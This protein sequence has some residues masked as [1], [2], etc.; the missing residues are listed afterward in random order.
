MI[1]KL[2]PWLIAAAAGTIVASSVLPTAIATNLPSLIPL[3]NTGNSSVQPHVCGSYKLIHNISSATDTQ[4]VAA[5]GSTN[6]YVCDFEF[7]I[8]STAD[9][10][11]LETG[12]S[13]T[14]GGL[15]QI[16]ITHNG[17]ANMTA[18]ASNAFYRG[19]NVGASNQLC[20]NTSS[21]GPLDIGVF[22]DQY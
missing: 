4:I 14:C 2:V 17:S 10:F 3:F 8:G 5:S 13:G 12:T 7:S 19:L 22:Y 15:T 16:G 21:A 1:K 18:K 11:Y 20:V 6:I 9:S